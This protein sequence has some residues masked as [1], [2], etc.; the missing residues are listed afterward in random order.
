MRTKSDLPALIADDI[1]E[2]IVHRL[3]APGSKLPTEKEMGEQ[4]SVSRVVVREAIARLRH[5]GLV[6]SHQ[7]RGVFVA[8]PEDGRFLSIDDQALS[9]PEDYQKLYDLRKILESGTAALAAIHRDRYDLDQMEREFARMAA[10]DVDA[11]T[12]VDADISFHRA[13]ATASHNPFLVLFITFVDARLKESIS[14]ALSRLDFRKT[15]EISAIEHRTIL[16]R[17]GR[18][19]SEGARIAMQTHLENSSRRLGI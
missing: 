11:E 15:I 10:S 19:D 14:L 2:Q 4:H 12:Y 1:R 5:E 3:L 17:I 8:S 7:G 18:R 13:I 9:R 16:D 6:T